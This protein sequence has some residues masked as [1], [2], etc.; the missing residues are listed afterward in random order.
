MESTKHHLISF[1]C[2]VLVVVFHLVR[3]PESHL[4]HLQPLGVVTSLCREWVQDSV[5]VNHRVAATSG[6]QGMALKRIQVLLP[7]ITKIVK[8]P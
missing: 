1:L 8:K 7:T 4:G 6:I 2:P 5:R 3:R